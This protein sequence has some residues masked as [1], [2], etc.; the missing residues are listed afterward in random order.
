MPLEQVIFVLRI[1]INKLCN[2]EK[3]YIKI[4]EWLVEAV[5]YQANDINKN[6]KLLKKSIEDGDA[7]TF[8]YLNAWNPHNKPNPKNYKSLSVEIFTIGQHK[9]TGNLIARGFLTAG[10]SSRNNP[11]KW[12]TFLLSNIRDVR[13]LPRKARVVRSLYHSPDQKMSKIFSDL[14]NYYTPSG[15]SDKFV[16][17][18]KPPVEK[19]QVKSTRIMGTPEK[20]KS[21]NKKKSMFQQPQKPTDSQEGEFEEDL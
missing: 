8:K 7:V 2:V 20:E 19:G 16:K 14:I 17:R 1:F 3:R 11:I 18:T 6:F 5:L 13:I 21:F 10:K 9:D 4:T 12:R 15:F